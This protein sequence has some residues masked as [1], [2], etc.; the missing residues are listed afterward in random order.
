M[1]LS[2][3]MTAASA[4]DISG[5]KHSIIQLEVVELVA[6][7]IDVIV[8]ANSLSSPDFATSRYCRTSIGADI[9]SDC[10]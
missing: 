3:S 8:G 7:L 4:M 9:T 5:T 6:L 1:L 10:T 2:I